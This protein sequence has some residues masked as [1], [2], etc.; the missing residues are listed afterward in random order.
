MS[1]CPQCEKAKNA[2]TAL[3]YEVIERDGDALAQGKIH[4]IEAMSELTVTEVYPVVI[5]EG[6]AV[7]EGDELYRLIQ[8]YKE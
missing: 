3:S 2:L 4:D 5:V 1:G 7:R 8:E 6:R